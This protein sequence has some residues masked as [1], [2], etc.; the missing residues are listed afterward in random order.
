MGSE[1]H[2]PPEQTRLDE[3][4]KRCVDFAQLGKVS[5]WLNPIPELFSN[6]MNCN[7]AGVLLEHKH[8]NLTIN[9]KFFLTLDHDGLWLVT[10]RE[11]NRVVLEASSRG[12]GVENVN[13]RVYITGEWERKITVRPRDPLPPPSDWSEVTFP[14][15][16]NAKRKRR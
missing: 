4:V 1:G 9:V 11:E 12:V 6:G 2:F 10:V 16:P 13:A 15:S 3:L 14:D 8:D 7:G 5:P